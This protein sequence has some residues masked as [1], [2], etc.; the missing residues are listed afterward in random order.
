LAKISDGPADYSRDN[1]IL[2]GLAVL[3]IHVV[4]L[5]FCRFSVNAAAADQH[6]AGIKTL[7]TQ[8]KRGR[9]LKKCLLRYGTMNW[10]GS[11]VSDNDNRK[12][13]PTTMTGVLALS[14]LVLTQD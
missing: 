5:H 3:T 12:I 1:W 14:R 2:A 7:H 4:R 6:R 9:P 11:D 10:N 13:M 8:I